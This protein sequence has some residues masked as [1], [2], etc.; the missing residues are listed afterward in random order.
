M[1]FKIHP[2]IGI[3]RMGDSPNSF[4]LAPEQM[5]QLPIDCDQ[6]GN[7]ILSPNGQEQPI[8]NFKD[9]KGR[10]R[11]QGARFRVY[12]YDDGGAG[13]EIEVGQTIQMTNIKSGQLIVG[14]VT[15]IEWTVYLAN[16][17]ASWYEFQETAGE[18]GYAP[19]H[20][21]RN[22]DVKGSDARA[23]LIIDPGPLTVSY[24]NKKQR[25][26]QFAKGK[27]PGFTQT[28]PPPLVPNSIDTLGDLIVTQQNKYNRL[29][30]LGGHGNSG[31]FKTGF[32]N[33][34]I[35]NF[36]NNDGWFDDTSDGPVQARIKYK[37]ISADGI[38]PDPKQPAPTGFAAVENSAWVIVGYPRY[39]PQITDVVTMDDLVYNVAVRE[40]GYNIYMYGV[41]PFDG[42]HTPPDPGNAK[43]L[44]SWRKSAQYNSDYYPYFWRDIWSLLTRPNNYQWVM[45]FDPFTGGQPHDTTP[46]SQNNFDPDLLS[47]PPYEG[48]DPGLREQRRQYRQRIW[49]VL[50][51]PGQENLY[52]AATDPATPNFRPVLMPYLCGDNPITNVAASKYL[53]LTDTQLFLL[54]QWAEGKFINEKDEDIPTTPAEPSPPTGREL[55]QGILSNSL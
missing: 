52:M 39:A 6:E 42:T 9:D 25:T 50:R 47:V 33:P 21:L 15:D 3:A 46:G 51:K 29:V 37:I 43:T 44:A 22:A 24:K 36:A 35:T 18:H 48:E 55:D 53:R 23:Q 13:K 17:K 2:A 26:A 4:Y 30:V 32:G 10:I 14:E 31:S 5:G 8:S 20:P 19:S 40:F 49:S 28:F 45:D 16:K 12:A 7:A 54:K 34:V 38:K 1:R 27:N 41:A 11:R